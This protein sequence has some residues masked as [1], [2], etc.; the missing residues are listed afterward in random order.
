MEVETCLWNMT[1]GRDSSL[2]VKLHFGYKKLSYILL[3]S[4]IITPPSQL[5]VH[6]T[7]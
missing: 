3:A 4:A 1:F 6:T 5:P 7:N 2:C